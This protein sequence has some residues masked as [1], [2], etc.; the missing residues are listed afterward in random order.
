MQ[1]SAPAAPPASDTTA[2]SD[3]NSANERLSAAESDL[4]LLQSG[5]AA[6]LKQKMLIRKAEDH[7]AE[8]R[9]TQQVCRAYRHT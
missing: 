4:A 5:G 3:L 1:S 6:T 2:D 7:L 9:K 8:M